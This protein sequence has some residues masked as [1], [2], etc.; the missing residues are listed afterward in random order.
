LSAAF[1]SS[2]ASEGADEAE[3]VVGHGEAVEVAL[4]GH[5]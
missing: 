1:V 5:Q 3:D 4:V 2:H